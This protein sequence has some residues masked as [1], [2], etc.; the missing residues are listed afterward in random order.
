MGD[1]VDRSSGLV[2]LLT[3]LSGAGKSTLAHALVERLASRDARQVTLLDGDEVR[4]MLSR[5]LGFSHEDRA[6]NLRRIGWVA[7]LVARHGGI[8]V[9]S[10]I[11]PYEH[12]RQEIRAMA[13]A[14]GRFVLVYVS[15]PLEVCEHRDP[16]GLYAQARRGEIAQFT[17]VSDPYEPPADADVSLDLSTMTTAEA[18]ESVL[19]HLTGLRGTPAK[20][21]AS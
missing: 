17:G 6:L 1:A 18:A 3:G 15:T 21:D 10:A 14:V 2:V 20:D 11:A 9:C 4:E 7:A 5:G 13:E 12:S 8:A 16:K 19:T